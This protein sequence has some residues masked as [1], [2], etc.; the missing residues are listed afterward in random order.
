ML[1]ALHILKVHTETHSVSKSCL[2]KI[3]LK[4]ENKYL[5]HHFEV[6]VAVRNQCMLGIRYV[7][8]RLLDKWPQAELCS[9][10]CMCVFADQRMHRRLKVQTKLSIQDMQTHSSRLSLGPEAC[11]NRLNQFNL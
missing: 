10:I 8:V 1:N 2:W 9:S 11:P 6:D 7:E 5:Q 3:H 4:S